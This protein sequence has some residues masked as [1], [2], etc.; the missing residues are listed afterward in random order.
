MSIIC[1]SSLLGSR[2]NES[3]SD[4]KQVLQSKNACGCCNELPCDRYDD[5][6]DADFVSCWLSSQLQKY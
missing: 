3:K 2:R 1:Q 6:I 5:G 4:F